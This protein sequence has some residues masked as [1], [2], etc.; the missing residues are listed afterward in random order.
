[1]GTG[2]APHERRKAGKN[3]SNST[4]PN[5]KKRID[6]LREGTKQSRTIH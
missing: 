6:E 3:L 4:S 2:K 5:G 1:M